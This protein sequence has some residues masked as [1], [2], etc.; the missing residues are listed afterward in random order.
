M[1]TTS[2]ASIHEL[3]RATDTELATLSGQL[4]RAESDIEHAVADLERTVRT[5]TTLTLNG[6]EDDL[7]TL[8]ET[9]RQWLA[10]NPDH[11]FAARIDRGLERLATA[12]AAAE[13]LNDEIAPLNTVYFKAGGWSRFFVVHGGH[14][15]SS[16]ECST[17]NNGRERTR[18]GWLPN[19]SGRT[20]AEAVAEHGAILCTICFPT[21]PTAWTNHYEL[22]AAQKAADRC[23]GSGTLDYPDETARTGYYTGNYGICRRCD[24]KVTITRT[25]KMRAHKPQAG[26]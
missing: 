26:N 8:D 18:L 12:R 5:R 22:Q 16:T 1:N 24:Q 14:I 23:P 4:H 3:A 13:T 9:L 15:H 6:V 10:A 17:C 7:D 11:R 2:G 19:L 20:E 21:A 25:G